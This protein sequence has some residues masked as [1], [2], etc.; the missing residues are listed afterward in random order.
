MITSNSNSRIKN[1]SALI[2]NKKD[3]TK[4]GLFV[5]E[6]VKLFL[7]AD[8][9]LIKEVYVSEGFAEKIKS[10]SKDSEDS[11]IKKASEKLF[12]LISKGT[13]SEGST[14]EIVADSVFKKMSDTVT[15]QGIITVLEDKKLNVSDFLY[16]EERTTILVLEGLQ[17]PGNIGTIIRTAEAAGV[18]FILADKNTVDNHSSK[19]I[20][21]TMGSIFRVPVIYTDDLNGEINKLKEKGFS[22]YAAHLRGDKTYREIEYSDKSIILIGNE[23]NGLSDEISELADVLVKIPMKGKVESLNAAVAAAL[24]MFECQ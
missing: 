5:V 7:E 22:V 19:V 23:G 10:S 1:V 11:N 3:R 18:S 9:D 12:T 6:G 4:Q 2:S 21:S 8:A 13:I 15:P 14:Y 20:R 24:M 17:D 16:N